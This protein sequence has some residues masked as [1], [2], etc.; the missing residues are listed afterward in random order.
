MKFAQPYLLNLLWMLIPVS[1]IMVYGIFTREKI[2]SQFAHASM[3]P[4]IAPGLDPKRR[5]IKAG[6]IIMASG[7]AIVALSGPQL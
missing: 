2:L 6:L 1:G 7:F 3:F 4:L 5:W